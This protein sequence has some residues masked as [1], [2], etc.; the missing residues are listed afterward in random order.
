MSPKRLTGDDR[1]IKYLTQE[2]VKRLFEAAKERS[3][4]DRLL[5]AFLYRFGM[6]TQE[7][8]DLP[9]DAVD[10]K[11]WEVTVRGAKGGLTR[12]YSI[13]SDLKPL[14]R[15]WKPSGATY[16]SGRQGPLGRIRVWQ[17]F[18]QAAK[19][20]GL[21]KDYGVHSLRHAAAVHALDA[22]LNTEDVRD[23]L[24]HRKLATTDVYAN[25]STKRRQEYLARLSKSDAVVKLGR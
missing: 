16:F 4:R 1:Q 20:G 13:P 25:L 18:K 5:L 8:C 2:Q 3:A 7:A 23:L 9:A 6:R 15:K 11:R 12:T 10:T 22:G 14:A 21:P 17:I 19:E 24:R